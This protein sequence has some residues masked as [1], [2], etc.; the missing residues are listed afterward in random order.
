M[1]F[2]VVFVIVGVILIGWGIW[3]LTHGGAEIKRAFLVGWRGYKGKG[4]EQKK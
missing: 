2:P 3:R 4:K 1:N